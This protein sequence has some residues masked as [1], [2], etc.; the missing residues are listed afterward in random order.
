[1]VIAYGILHCLANEAEVREG[2]AALQDATVHGG[3]NI[4]CAF[5]TRAQDLRG[6]PGF[7]PVLLEHR[8]YERLYSDWTTI[9]STDSDLCE[10]HP[11]NEI[12]HTHSMTRILA[13]KTMR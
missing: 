4:L 3:F 1:V 2:V 5:N 11:H 13:R 8:D 12:R 9:V 7:F 6:H 10:V